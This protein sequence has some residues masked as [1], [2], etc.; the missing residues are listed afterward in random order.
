MNTFNGIMR[1]SPNLRLDFE[2]LET[3]IRAFHRRLLVEQSTER[4]E[5]SNMDINRDAK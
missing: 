1:L 2:N 3:S 5:T 4:M